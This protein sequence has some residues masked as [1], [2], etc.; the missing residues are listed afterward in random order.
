VKV[1]LQSKAVG[2]LQAQSAWYLGCGLH[3]RLNELRVA[4]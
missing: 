1:A 3:E 2:T 4:R